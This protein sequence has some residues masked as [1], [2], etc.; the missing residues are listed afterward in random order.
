MFY[1]NYVYPVNPVDLFYKTMKIENEKKVCLITGGTSGIGLATA[2]GMARMDFTTIL[3]GRNQK[4]CERVCEKIRKQ[5]GNEL[6]SFLVADLSSQKDI[7]RL[8]EQFNADFERLDFLVNNAGAKFVSRLT[9][10]DGYEMTFAL[11]HLAYF[12][13]TKLLLDRLKAADSARIINVSSGAHGSAAIDFDDLQNERHYIG[14]QAYNQSKLANLLFT[15]E[16]ARRLKSTHI[17]ANAMAPGGVITNFCRNNGWVSWAR[18]VTAH[19]LARN[20][21]GP[22]KAAETILY[23]ATSSDVEKVTGKYFFDKKPA[24][25]SKASYDLDSARRLWVVSEAL[26]KNAWGKGHRA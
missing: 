25:S 17:T 15:Y 11:N 20:L 19:I 18:H 5:S 9:T 7:H 1:K 12:L 13:M 8:V 26:I 14:T 10:I 16:L 4:K 3:V 2:R 24:S 6:V 23:L 21:I 22:E